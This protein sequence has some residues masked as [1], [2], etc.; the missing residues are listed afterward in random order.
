[1]PSLSTLNERAAPMKQTEYLASPVLH[2]LNTLHKNRAAAFDYNY[3]LPTRYLRG[4]LRDRL[5][6]LKRNGG[7]TTLEELGALACEHLSKTLANRTTTRGNFY[8]TRLARRLGVAIPD[9]R[10]NSITALIEA[11]RKRVSKDSVVPTPQMQLPEV[12]IQHGQTV[13]S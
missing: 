4:V 1:M 8:L 5:T 13:A 11:R 3:A 2:A 6:D 7:T 9:R 12:R 10:Q